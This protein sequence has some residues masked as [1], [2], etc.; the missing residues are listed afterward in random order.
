MGVE[1][2]GSEVNALTRSLSTKGLLTEAE[3]DVGPYPAGYD[4]DLKADGRRAKF[5]AWMLEKKKPHFLTGYFSSLDEVQHET[6]PY[7]AL[8][9]ETLEGI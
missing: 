5:V 6:A 2:R 1:G 3:K 4:Y 8:T 9:F 7:S